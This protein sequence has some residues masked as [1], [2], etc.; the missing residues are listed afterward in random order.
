MTKINKKKIEEFIRVAHAGERGAIKIYEGQLLALNTFIQD[1]SLKNIEGMTVPMLAIL[2]KEDILT[3]ND[4]AELTTFELIDKEEGIFKSLDVE[5][6]LAN[7]MIM[8]A[9]KNWFD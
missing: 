6:E 4:F 2:A 8:E 3:L 1:E 9:R 7:S 5:E